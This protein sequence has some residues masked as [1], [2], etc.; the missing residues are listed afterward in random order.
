[1][2][3]HWQSI[4]DYIVWFYVV[5]HRKLIAQVEGEPPRQENVKVMIDEEHESETLD[6]F[7]LV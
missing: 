3:V 2:E 4:P 7:Q 5:S 1:M 6:T